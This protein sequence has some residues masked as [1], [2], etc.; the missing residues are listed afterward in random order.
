[1]AGHPTNSRQVIVASLPHAVLLH[2][3][4]RLPVDERARCCAAVVTQLVPATLSACDAGVVTAHFF[5][6]TAHPRY[7]PRTQGPASSQRGPT[8]SNLSY[9]AR[10]RA[11]QRLWGSVSRAVGGGR[12]P[13]TAARPW[14]GGMAS[15]RSVL[16][17]AGDHRGQ[18][19]TRWREVLTSRRAFHKVRERASPSPGEPRAPARGPLAAPR[20]SPRAARRRHAAPGAAPTRGAAPAHGSGTPM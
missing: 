17:V 3:S 7:S 14:R 10:A 13:T 15:P 1:M 16:G 19:P 9:S 11:R 6:R 18:G 20:R 12:G 2:I 5:C 8:R 4:L